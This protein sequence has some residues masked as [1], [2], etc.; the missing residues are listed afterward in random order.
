MKYYSIFVVHVYGSRDWIWLCLMSCYI[1]NFIKNID[2]L[3]SSSVHEFQNVF[4]DVARHDALFYLF[5]SQTSTDDP[6]SRSFIRSHHKCYYPL[7]FHSIY[8]IDACWCQRFWNFSFQIHMNKFCFAFN[9]HFYRFTTFNRNDLLAPVSIFSIQHYY[10]YWWLH[11]AHLDFEKR[12]ILYPAAVTGCE[13]P[14]FPLS[15]NNECIRVFVLCTLI[16]YNVQL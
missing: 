10:Y 7:L 2:Q 8:S 6:D 16:T 5:S 4:V 14:K 1:Y 9:L 12:Y 3:Q 13:N 11:F 15:N